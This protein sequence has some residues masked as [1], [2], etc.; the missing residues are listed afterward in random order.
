MT[1][2]L[3]KAENIY[4]DVDDNIVNGNGKVA[5]VMNQYDRKPKIKTKY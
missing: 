1:I 5:A 4:Y 3:I 2:G